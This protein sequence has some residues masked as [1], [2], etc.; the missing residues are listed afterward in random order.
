[1]TTVHCDACDSD[2]PVVELE[3]VEQVLAAVGLAMERVCLACARNRAAE[4]EDDAE[5]ETLDGAAR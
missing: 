1:V 3:L 4:W 5:W 2:F